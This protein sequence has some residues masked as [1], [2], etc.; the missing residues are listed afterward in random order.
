MF[1]NKITYN[2]EPE[3]H[4]SLTK[5]NQGYDKVIKELNEPVRDYISIKELVELENNNI[6][7]LKNIENNKK[8]SLPLTHKKVKN[9]KMSKL[10]YISYG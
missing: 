2:K 6:T 1:R 4:K 10:K 8:I 7:N 5:I 9:K 3:W